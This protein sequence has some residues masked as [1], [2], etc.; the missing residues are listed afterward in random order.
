MRVALIFCFSLFFLLFKGNESAYATATRISQGNKYLHKASST[1]KHHNPFHKNTSTHIQKTFSSKDVNYIEECQ[2]EDENNSKKALLSFKQAG[3]FC[4]AL[5][6]G[7]LKSI[8]KLA[9]P[10]CEHLSYTSSF[11]YLL[12]RVFRI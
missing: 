7:N 10:Y 4:Y 6:V 9:L 5:L 1:Q 2:D 12:L 8:K 3:Y 11:K